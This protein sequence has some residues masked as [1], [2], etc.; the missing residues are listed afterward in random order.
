MDTDSYAKMLSKSSFCLCPAGD[1]ATP[2]QRLYD[3]IAAGCVPILIGVDSKSLP[4]A[5]QIDYNAF[6]AFASRSGFQKDPVYAIETVLHRLTP[7]LATMRH[8]LVDAR[9]QLLYGTL[10]PSAGPSWEPSNVSAAEATSMG[11]VATLL[12]REIALS[13]NFGGHGLG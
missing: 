3:A 9:R 7:R 10:K 11:E 6:A 12:L 8:A 1:L 13:V 4:F 2:G 5:R